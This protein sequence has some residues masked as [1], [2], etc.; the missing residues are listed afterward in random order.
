MLAH[1]EKKVEDRH[2]KIEYL[3][4]EKSFLD[5]I[6]NNFHNFLSAIIW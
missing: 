1:R 2:L 3:K 6:K 4:S 5:K